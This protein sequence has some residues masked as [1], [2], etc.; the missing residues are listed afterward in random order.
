VA[1][2]VINKF[3]SVGSSFTNTFDGTLGSLNIPKGATRSILRID[4]VNN[5]VIPTDRTVIISML[6]GG[7]YGIGQTPTV[8]GTI[9][10]VN[11]AT[12]YEFTGTGNFSV[13]GNWLNGLKPPYQLPAGYEIVINPANGECLLDVPLT[14][15][16]GAKLTVAPGKAFNV[17]GDL[18]I[19]K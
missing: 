8:N 15:M 1:G 7:D 10:N 19:K 6:E 3:G 14:I 17:K 4:P 2:S 12:K 16:P 9:M 13:T 5:L 11:A 18:N